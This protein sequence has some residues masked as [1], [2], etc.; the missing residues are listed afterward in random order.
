M[1]IYTVY[2]A[3]DLFAAY[4]HVATH[5]PLEREH[6]HPVASV[7]AESLEAV[8]QLTNSIEQ[9]WWYHR[10]VTP[11]PGAVPTR[12][13]SVGD[14]VVQ[15]HTVWMVDRFGFT[16]TR[17]AARSWLSRLFSWVHGEEMAR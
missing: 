10:A 13:T 11:I 15:G 17:W 16:A 5:K 7:E 2:H 1:P 4:Q 12:S 6:Y 9:P 3:D 14:V 8:F